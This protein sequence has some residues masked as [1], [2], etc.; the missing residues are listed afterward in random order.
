MGF[1][2][3]GSFRV[4]CG[5]CLWTHCEAEIKLSRNGDNEMTHKAK[6]LLAV[7]SGDLCVILGTSK[8]NKEN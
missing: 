7:K 8:V 4:A 6:A 2:F 5:Y 3:V 1:G